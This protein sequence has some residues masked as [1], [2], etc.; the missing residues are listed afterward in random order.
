MSFIDETPTIRSIRKQL[1]K[2]GCR[3]IEQQIA[4]EHIL[5]SPKKMF[6][7]EELIEDDDMT[8]IEAV[9]QLMSKEIDQIEGII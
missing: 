1:E 3:D 8:V 2:F 6:K 7:L 9:N 4:A 5:E